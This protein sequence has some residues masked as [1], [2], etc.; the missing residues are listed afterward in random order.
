MWKIR[1]FVRLADIIRPWFSSHAQLP[2]PICM[3]HGRL[4]VFFAGRNAIQCSSTGFVDLVVSR[5][6]I[7]V[8]GVSGDPVLRP[9]DLGTFDEHGVF[10]SCVVRHDGKYYM[11]YVAWN[12]G[13]EPPLFYATIGLATSEDGDVFTK[14][15]LVPLLGRSEHDPCLITSPH[16]FVEGSRWLMTYVSGFKWDR[17]EDGRLR[18]YYDIKI[19]TADGPLGWKRTGH[20]A[21]PLRDGERNVARPAVIRKSPTRLSMWFSYVNSVH[22]KYRIG[23]AES[24][25][26]VEWERDDE[27]AG[28]SELP[29]FAADMMCYPA[30]FQVGDRLFMVFNGDRYGADG[31]GVAEWD[32]PW[33]TAAVN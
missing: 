8:V 24:S 1:K 16:V 15:G 10:P 30:L 29:E 3:D 7:E 5:A 20:S 26:G 17:G 12:K 32:R 21:I 19:A 6:D 27:S 31:F 33:P 11:Y 9:G 4:R 14:H 18:S 28:F 13:A 23:Y 2:T 25:D 22:G